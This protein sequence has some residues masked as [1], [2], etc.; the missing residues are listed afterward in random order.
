[1][2][3]TVASMMFFIILVGVSIYLVLVQRRLQRYEM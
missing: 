3:A 1:M 2:G